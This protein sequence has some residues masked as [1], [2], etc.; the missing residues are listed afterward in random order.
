MKERKKTTS[1]R[2]LDSLNFRINRGDR[3]NKKPQGS[4]YD[5]ESDNSERV[6]KTVF[7][8]ITIILDLIVV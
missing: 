2:L 7:Y 5:L 4:V 8:I 6:G 1:G 3:V